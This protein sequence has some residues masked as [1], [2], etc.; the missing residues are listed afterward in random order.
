MAI[1]SSTSTVLRPAH[2]GGRHRYGEKPDLAGSLRAEISRYAE[3][4]LGVAVAMRLPRKGVPCRPRGDIEA[5]WNDAGG[6]PIPDCGPR[7][8]F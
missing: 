7:C 1:A 6:I 3:R 4:T 8:F 5:F 2:P